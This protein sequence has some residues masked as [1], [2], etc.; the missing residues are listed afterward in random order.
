M[1]VTNYCA[2]QRGSKCRHV[3]FM[4]ASNSLAHTQPVRHHRGCTVA[5]PTW[6]TNKQ[7]M[8][9]VSRWSSL[10]H[11]CSL[12]AG[13]APPWTIYSFMRTT[14]RAYYSRDRHRRELFPK[15]KKCHVC[16]TC[17]G[18]LY[19]W[20]VNPIRVVLESGWR[21]SGGVCVVPK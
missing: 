1:S 20:R 19:L 4:V 10:S 6:L 3:T 16:I 9:F 15:L 17:G 12:Y 21:N 11:V 8:I 5:R 7:F 2:Q 14:R 18:V 13:C